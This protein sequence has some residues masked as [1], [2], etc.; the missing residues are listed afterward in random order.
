MK[1]TVKDIMRYGPCKDYPLGR[2]K[3]LWNG[4]E[5]LTER[6]IVAL[7]IPRKDII[8]ALIG[9]M[10]DEQRNVFRCRIASRVLHLWDA[11]EIAK[12]YLETGNDKIRVAARYA[13]WDAALAAEMDYDGGVARDAALAAASDLAAARDAEIEAQIDIAIEILEGGAS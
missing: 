3:K 4:K 5:Y 12:E 10:T 2:V 7:N 6:E 11:P 1:V 9:L 13:A 8:C